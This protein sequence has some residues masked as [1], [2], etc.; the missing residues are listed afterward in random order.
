M[1][2]YKVYEIINNIN[3]HN[4]IG[5]TKLTL[6]VR[7]KLHKNSK[8]NRMP[9]VS[10]IKK[11]GHENFT[12]KLCEE[13]DTK[14]EAVEYEIQKIAELKPTYNIHAGGTGGPMYGPMN[15]MFGKKHSNGWIENKKKSMTGENNPMFNKTHTKETK[16]LLSELKKGNIPWNKGKKGLLSLETLEKLKKPKTEEHKT[17]L[18]K[19][20]RFTSPSGESVLVVGLTQFCLDN[21]LNKGAMSE[22]WNGK[23]IMHKGWKK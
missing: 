11:Y 15:G 10:A 16:K 4:Y 1:E 23:R 3:G 12:I 19:S 6:N 8:T 2:K 21:N 13:F 9:V 18:K 17:K 14:M 5:Y 7:F 22:I 20:Y